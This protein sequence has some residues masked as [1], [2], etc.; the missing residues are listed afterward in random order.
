MPF[1]DIWLDQGEYYNFDVLE[2]L[3]AEHINANSSLVEVLKNGNSIVTKKKLKE[4]EEYKKSKNFLYN[5]SNDNPEVLSQYKAR[6]AKEGATSLTNE[7]IE[8]RQNDKID[9]NIDELINRFSQIKSG[10]EQAGEYHNLILSALNII[11]YPNLMYPKKEQSLNEDRKRIDITYSNVANGGF[12]KHLAEK[13][14][15]V[16]PFVHIECKNYSKDIN[17]PEF[18]Q[19]AGRLNDYTGRFGMVMCRQIDNKK[20]LLKRQKDYLLRENKYIFVF[21]DEDVINL[22]N[23]SKYN[24]VTDLNKFLDSKLREL[25]L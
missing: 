9:I 23:F 13:T 25:L 20:D 18:D 16:A 1:N 10:R 6:K 12:F 3:K 15:L 21:D 24:N 11:F 19:I 17:N 4:Q 14:K 5:F 22:L 7:E 2:F 8:E